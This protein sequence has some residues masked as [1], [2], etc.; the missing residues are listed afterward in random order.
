MAP[1]IPLG[2]LVGAS[3]GLDLL[4]PVFLLSGIEH[5]RVDPGNTAFTPLAFD[6]YPWSHSLAM[7]GIWGA[8]LAVLARVRMKSAHSGIVLGFVL[9]SHWVLDFITHRQDLPLW[10]DGPAV[11]M[12]LWNSVGATIIVEGAFFAAAIAA[13][14]RMFTPLDGI[15]RWAFVA[16]I[17]FTGTIW[18]SGPWSPPPPNAAAVGAVALAMW[19]FPLWGAWID[20]HRGY[21][22]R[23]PNS[24]H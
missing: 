22:A 18:I 20:R 6:F 5:V 13:Y 16:L 1:R 2:W 24:P 14:C 12:G 15:G 3:Y 19:I 7:A 23:T 8:V 17:A 21:A 10:P 9:V 4:W 11:G